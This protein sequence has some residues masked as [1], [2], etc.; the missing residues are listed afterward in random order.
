MAI[1]E[2]AD[3][4]GRDALIAQVDSAQVN[5]YCSCGCAT[6]DLSVDRTRPAA[7]HP[8]GPIPNEATVL[9][10]DGEPVGGIIVFVDEGYLELLEIY[11]FDEP[12]SPFPPPDRLASWPGERR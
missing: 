12:I 4:D 7:S 1:L 9:D 5:S 3:F 2:H 8:A 10:A 11:W 6:V